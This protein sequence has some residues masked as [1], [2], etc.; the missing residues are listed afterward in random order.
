MTG[1]TGLSAFQMQGTPP[2][3]LK[4][5]KD[6]DIQSKIDE[7]NRYHPAQL[8]GDGSG[9]LILPHL[10]LIFKLRSLQKSP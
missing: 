9:K 3:G 6:M 7:L 1:V 2:P 4:T 5:S 10:P 8:T